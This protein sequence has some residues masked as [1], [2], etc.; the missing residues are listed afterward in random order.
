MRNEFKIPET[1]L[2]RF[3]LRK[4]HYSEPLS[5]E[6]SAF[7]ATVLFDGVPFC[8]AENDGNGGENLYSPL[9]TGPQG[10]KFH[11]MMSGLRNILCEMR[12]RTPWDDES[13]PLDLELIIGV[14]LDNWLAVREA[15]KILRRI[16]YIKAADGGVYSL[17]AH[18]KPTADNL[19]K[20]K[21]CSWWHSG[22]VLLNE[23][24]VEQVAERLSNV[25]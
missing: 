2:R 7:A 8:H 25:R 20:V 19:A 23:L 11:E 10:A 18:L 13:M 12:I 5:H 16:S 1:I 15:K 21:T 4:V 17:P 22:N 9:K 24:S 6:T 3:D 14:L